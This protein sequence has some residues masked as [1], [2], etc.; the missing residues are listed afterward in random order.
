MQY[1]TND[2][3]KSK[4]QLLVELFM[5]QARQDVPVAPC[6]PSLEIR[7]LRAALLLEEC[8]ETIEAMGIQVINSSGQQIHIRDIKYRENGPGNIIEV[9]DGLADLEVVGSCGTASAFGIAQQP[10]FEA[11]AGNNLLKF[12][13]GHSFRAD[14]KLIKPANHPAVTPMIT[15]ILLAQGA[16]PA[17]LA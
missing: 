8:L 16:E 13:P 9:A 10:I 6:I 4:N 11:V 1:T 2:Q 12:A 14:G 3:F 15:K 7:K 5:R 17:D